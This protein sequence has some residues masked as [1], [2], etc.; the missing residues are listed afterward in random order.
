MCFEGLDTLSTVY[1]NEIQVASTDN[2]HRKYIF[3]IKQYLEEGLN[4]ISVKFESPVKN[5]NK[6]FERKPIWNSE[7]SMKGHTYLRKSHT[8]FGWDWG[9]QLPDMGI[10]RP[11]YLK[12]YSFAKIEDYYVKQKHIQDGKKVNL[13]IDIKFF[14]QIKIFWQ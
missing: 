5:M 8:Q 6:K 7:Y 4:T 10:W 13:D 12:F 3:S 2:M 1:I 11:V 14:N 9:P